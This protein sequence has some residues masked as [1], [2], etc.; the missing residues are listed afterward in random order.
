MADEMTKLEV[1]AVAQ[2][3]PQMRLFRLGMEK[4]WSYI[5]G[6]V[7]ILSLDG[8]AQSYF[9]IASAPE[10]AGGMEVLI[11][12]STGSSHAYY[13][14][15]QKDTVLVKGPVGKGFP[16]ENYKGR[17]ILLTA[18]GSAISP[19]RSVLRSVCHRRS[20]FGKVTLVFG[21]R[22]PE[23]IPFRKEMDAW[24]AKNI[25]I[26]LSASRP[27]PTW[28]GRTGHV[29][30]HFGDALKPLQNPLV[31]ICGMK[32]MMEQGKAELARLNVAPNDILSNY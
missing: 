28:M 4:P 16:I 14:L 1:T 6:Q 7:A 20:D 15:P 30:A 2:E 12:D 24:K 29:Q 26:T 23:D 25:D 8:K 18:V 32:E 9:A 10:D 3:T 31:L 21:F 27:D 22:N 5:P 19:M 11:R 17:D 13:S